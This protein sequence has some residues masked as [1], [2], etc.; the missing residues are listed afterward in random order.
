MRIYLAARYSRRLELCG[1]REKIRAMGHQVDAVWLNGEHQISD[2]GTPI[3]EQGE[4]LVEGRLR[5][6]ETLSPD[7]IGERADRLRQKFARDDFRDVLMCDML[8]AF[9]EPPRSDQGRGRGG[10]HVELGIALGLMKQVVV[11]GYRENI[12]HWL[13][14][15]H[16]LATWSECESWLSQQAEL[17]IT[18]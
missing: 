18:A 3:G 5:P 12:F 10:R 9:T 6:G 11:V 16:F 1:Y 14:D 2:V 13:E 4:N 15:V 8:I 7:E 17:R